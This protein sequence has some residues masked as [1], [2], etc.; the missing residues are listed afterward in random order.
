MAVLPD[1]WHSALGRALGDVGDGVSSVL[2]VVDFF[3]DNPIKGILNEY[4]LILT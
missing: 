4:I 2:S 3:Q 1:G